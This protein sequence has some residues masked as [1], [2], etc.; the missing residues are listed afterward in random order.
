MI[1][2]QCSIKNENENLNKINYVLIKCLIPKKKLFQT[3]A[4]QIK[5]YEQQFRKVRITAVIHFV[6]LLL[7][8]NFD[9]TW[10]D[11]YTVKNVNK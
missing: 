4:A 9:L 2:T 8:T 5:E 7:C 1:F 3:L 10:L 6:E 11:S